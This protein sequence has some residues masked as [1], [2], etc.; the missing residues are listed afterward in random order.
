MT[1][2][3]P[4]ERNGRR[5]VAGSV[6]GESQVFDIVGIGF[7]PANLALAIAIEE[8]NASCS[9]GDEITACFVE[10][11]VRFGWH[12]GM[13]LEG[14]TMQIAFPKD[15]A[16]FR[17]PTSSYSFVAYLHDRGRLVDFVNHQTF[18]P[19]RTEFHDY[20]EWAAGRVSADVRYDCSVRHVTGGREPD[21]S[22]EMLNIETD[23]GTIR[24]RNVAFAAG[25]RERI[26]DWATTSRHCFHNHQFLSRIDA[27]GELVHNRFVVLGAGQSA[28]EVVQYLHS[29]FPQAEVHSVFS[30]FGYSPADDSPY[31]NRI[32]DPASVDELHRA[33]DHERRRLLG[34]HRGTNYSVVDIELI[35]QLYASEY[36]ERVRDR[37]RLFMRRASDVVGVRDIADGVEV[38]VRSNL[39]GLSDTLACDALVLATGFVPAPLAPIFGDLLPD[40]VESPPVERDYRMRTAEHIRSGIYLQG[41][42]EESHGLTSSLLSNVA[43]RSGDIVKSIVDRRARTN[44][45]AGRSARSAVR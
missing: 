34:L 6:P 2:D 25:L 4:I 33:P 13:L 36:Q 32:F 35:N 23:R 9:S 43:V 31:A 1:T 44:V 21:G 45:L 15:L 12:R 41:G 3:V 16:T 26:P 29:S 10:R 7:G 37:R 27:L 18:F 20:L 42:T 40:G 22:V 8:H 5:R 30:R 14:A 28:A 17:N 38:N 39:D 24:A 19:T 11:Q